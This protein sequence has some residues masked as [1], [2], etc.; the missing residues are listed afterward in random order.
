MKENL[1]GRVSALRSRLTSLDAM[2]SDVQ[3]TSLLTGMRQE[4]SRE[5]DA[6]DRAL[7]QSRIF[8]AESVNVTIPGSLSAA[9]A[10][11][12]ALRDS[13]SKDPTA[14][15]LKKGNHWISLVKA[16]SDA[17]GDIGNET[18]T[19]WRNYRALIFTGETPAVIR[20][21]MA[22]T[23]KNQAAYR[24]YEA[25]HE[26]FRAAFETLPQKHSEIEQARLLAKELTEIATEFDFN[27]PVEVKAF[28]D[29]VQAGGAPL[30]H[31]TETVISWLKEN[32]AF[33]SYRIVPSR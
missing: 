30:G 22:G 6:L 33:D 28:L 4:L 8:A 26:V 5:V 2:A 12:S 7:S 29:T 15:T 23:E 27:V 24:R 20:G 32:H 13:F 19:A 17:A 21:R 9:R 31:L 18:R 14:K 3:E 10:R 16:L 25:K 1:P 11:A